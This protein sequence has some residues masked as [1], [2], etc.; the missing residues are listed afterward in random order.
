MRNYMPPA[1]RRLLR[2]FENRPSVRQCVEANAGSA[3]AL[4]EAY[5][6]CLQWIERMRTVHLEYA[7]EYINRQVSAGD[8]NPTDVGTG[9]TPF[10][11]YLTKHRDETAEQRLHLERRAKA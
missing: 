4:A 7:S 3:P 10:M 1:H 8:A 11:S 9:G 6:S 5:D 2:V